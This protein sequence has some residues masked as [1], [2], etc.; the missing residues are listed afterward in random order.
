MGD[1][2]PHPKIIIS[3]IIYSPSQ[4]YSQKLNNYINRT[5]KNRV[6]LSLLSILLVEEQN[7][8]FPIYLNSSHF[9]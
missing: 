6:R 2:R 7:G 9:Y 8:H 3:I 5:V 1:K 4:V